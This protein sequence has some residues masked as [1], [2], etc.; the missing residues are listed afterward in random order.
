MQED[1]HFAAPHQYFYR[2]S[3]SDYFEYAAPNKYT[4]F[5]Q[6]K[7]PVYADIPFLKENFE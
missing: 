6:Y 2:K 4:T 7:K 1:V 3:G 5:F